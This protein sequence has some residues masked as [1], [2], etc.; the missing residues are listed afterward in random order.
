MKINLENSIC[1]GK[2]LFWKVVYNKSGVA[3]LVVGSSR[4]KYYAVKGIST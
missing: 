3:S 2:H 1:C 4:Q